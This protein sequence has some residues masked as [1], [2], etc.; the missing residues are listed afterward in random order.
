MR[1]VV[2]GS[3]AGGGSPQ[4]NCRC[5]VCD[6][7]WRG[8]PR[9]PRRTQASIAVSADDSSWSL[10]NCSPDIREQIAACKWLQPAG[11]PRGTPISDIV[12]TN[13]DID[14][15][16]GLLSLREGQPFTIHATQEVLAILDNNRVFDVLDRR[17]VTRQPIEFGTPAKIGAGLSVELFPV[18][19]KVPLYLEDEA[20]ETRLKSGHTAGIR[21]SSG[22]GNFFYIPG[23]ADIDEELA[24]R[25]RGAVAVLFDGTLWTDDEMIECETG[26]KTGRRMGHMPVSGS[27]GSL[28]AFEGLGI[29]RLIYVHINNTNPMLIAGS[30]ERLEVERA[31][32]EV[33]HDGLEIV[34]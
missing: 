28:T 29:S 6:L 27:D 11:R 18:A 10:I 8:D 23:C 26:S 9:V 5:R 13:G 34:L 2:L 24:G 25:L 1:I 30:P 20:P 19:G 21:I 12:L 31:G 16:G 3:A 17:R 4:W 22:S 33:A 7:A 14:H 32:A 15:I